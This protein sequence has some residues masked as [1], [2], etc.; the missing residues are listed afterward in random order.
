MLIDVLWCDLSV[1]CFC[2]IWYDFIEV[3][4][5]LS[6]FVFGVVWCL[7]VWFR[8]ICLFFVLIDVYCVI[9]DLFL[10]DLE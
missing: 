2:M 10:N 8:V 3:W 6:W 5:G 4:L 1:I 9:C 7:L